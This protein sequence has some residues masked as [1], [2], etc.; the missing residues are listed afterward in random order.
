MGIEV[1]IDSITLDI[2]S[3]RM[4]N[5]VS[6]MDILKWLDNF[7]KEEVPL[8]IEFLENFRVFTSDE[9]E[10]V[11]HKRLNNVL[12]ETPQIEK[13]AVHPIGVFG[14]SGSMMAYLL[15]KTDAYR[16]NPNR[17]KL[18]AS[19]NEL[20]GLSDEYKTLVVIDDFVGSGKSVLDYFN[21]SIA[22]VKN[23]FSKMIFIGIAGMKEGIFKIRPLFNKIEIPSSNIFKK[24]FSYDASYFG[25]R[26]HQENRELA[27]KYGS[28]LTRGERLK[29]GNLKY[30]N[31]LG[32]SNSQAMVGFFYGCP[33]NSLPIFWQGKESD[34]KW[35]PLI[36]RLNHH[37]ISKAKEFRKKISFELS[38]VREYGSENLSRA[39]A[40][41]NV[42]RGKK[43]FTSVSH[44]DFS[45]YAILKLMRKRNSEFSICQKLGIS[46]DDYLTYLNTGK[47]N[48]I[49]TKKHQ[50][51]LY[52]LQLYKD[53]KKC[54][55]HHY[56][57]L[58]EYDNKNEVKDIVYVPKKFNG[59]S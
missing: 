18:C 30:R 8:A 54:I 29:S 47:K 53:A 22:P 3:S 25:Y 46:H 41:H 4:K 1:N 51:S 50:I 36:P 11:F 44:I 13:V 20:E 33:N 23:N 32:F 5:L 6:P 43:N 16:N 48:G 9:I 2:L 40:T 55:E 57:M 42:Q 7:E 39:F 24:A 15:R 59:R 49:F 35:V 12:K 26:K 28:Q 34:P 10:E 38:L 19:I 45:L 31:A 17:I 52:G 14:K 21:D 56:K 37:K 58:Y 27:Y